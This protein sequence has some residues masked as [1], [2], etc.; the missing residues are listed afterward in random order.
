MSS[1]RFWYD[2]LKVS[3]RFDAVSVLPSPATALATMITRRPDV[4]CASWST[5]ARRR[6]CSREAGLML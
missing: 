5:A 6:Y 3:A 2:S 4:L 1:T